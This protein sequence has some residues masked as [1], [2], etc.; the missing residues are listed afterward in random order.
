M[1]GMKL[2]ISAIMLGQYIQGL[3]LLLL[4]QGLVGYLVQGCPDTLDASDR[5]IYNGTDAAKGK[6]TLA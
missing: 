1:N 2:R 6:G 5:Q 3:Q 4:G